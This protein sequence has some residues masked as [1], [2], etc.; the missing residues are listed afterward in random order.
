MPSSPPPSPRTPRGQGTGASQEAAGRAPARSRRRRGRSRSPVR[1]GIAA[2]R[3]L[4]FGTSDQEKDKKK[5]LPLK[6]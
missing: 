1:R 6:M 3:E 2:G 4:V 5:P